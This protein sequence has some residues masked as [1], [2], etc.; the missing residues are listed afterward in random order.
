M[1]GFG[2]TMLTATL[3]LAAVPDTWSQNG[4]IHLL[5]T[6]DEETRFSGQCVIAARERDKLHALDGAVPSEHSWQGG[7]ISCEISQVSARGALEVVLTKDG[8]RTRSR[9]EGEGS[10]V[11]LN[12]R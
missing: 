1:S 6:G 3:I 7:A 10:V 4:N 8:N 2:I 9:T 12:V 11:R 5:I